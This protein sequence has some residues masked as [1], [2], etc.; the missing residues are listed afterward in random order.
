MKILS[1]LFV[2]C[3]FLL[4]SSKSLA[5]NINTNCGDRYLTLVNPIRGR[6]LWSDKSL[7]PLK[8]QYAAVSS[9]GLPA[10]WLV[11]YDVLTDEELKN[12]LKQFNNQQELGLFLEVS[13]MLAGQAKVIY[14][15]DATWYS[16]RSVFLSAYSQSERKTLIDTLFNKFKMQ[17]GYYPK[18]VGAWWIDSYSLNYIKQKYHI[19]TAMI[20]ADQQTTD[21]YG[22]WGQWWG[23]PYYP[24][25]ANL[26]TPASNLKNKQDVV[27]I[28]WAQREPDLAYGKGTSSSNFSVQANDYISLGKDTNYFTGLI[29]S[30]LDC[31]NE[32]GQVTVGME[33]GMASVDFHPE[34][35]NQLAALKTINNLQAVTMKDFADKFAKVYPS[36]PEKMMISGQNSQWIMT[37]KERKNDRLGDAISYNQN[38]AF[39]DYFLADKS[40]FLNRIL[41]NKKFSGNAAASY[42]PYLFF[43]IVIFGFFSLFRKKLKIWL[44]FILFLPTCFGLILKSHNQF[45][46][47]VYYGPVFSNLFLVQAIVVIASFILI[48]FLGKHRQFKEK[49]WLFL[50]PLSFGLDLIVEQF[51]FSFIS[52]QYYLGFALN[53]LRI[54]GLSFNLPRQIHFINQE[55]PAYQASAFLRFNFS[56]IWDNT[57][58]SFVI[59]PLVH[60]LLFLLILWMMLKLPFKINKIMLVILMLTYLLFLLTIFQTN[61]RLV[62][63]L[64]SNF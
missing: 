1:F 2:F 6:E 31:Q 20:V 50:L 55:F 59:Y 41:T 17:F 22:V 60:F 35:L 8:D 43:L 48:W 42:Y 64:S 29:K 57:W 5:S 16:P 37:T 58:L 47:N 33:T 51:R 23:V 26:L 21:N 4:L 15:Y 27:I 40:D 19:K 53:P 28:Q 46:W 7:K 14:P 18:S 30:Y 12:Y 45:G 38:L 39:A 9:Y 25:K 61:P 36:F 10:T 11:Q 24:S 3:L 62:Q 34:Y 56:R 49:L 63:Q 13:K 44:V 54:I 32:L 52:G